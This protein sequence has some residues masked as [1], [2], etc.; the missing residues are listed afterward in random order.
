MMEL[1]TPL[2]IFCTYFLVTTVFAETKLRW[3]SHN[4]ELRDELDDAK[5]LRAVQSSMRDWEASHTNHPRKKRAVKRVCYGELGCFEDSGPFSYLEMLPSPPEEVNTKF[6]FYSTRNRSEQPLVELPYLNM[7]GEFTKMANSTT[8]E[9]RSSSEP[10]QKTSPF[11]KPFF[12]LNDMHR[13]DNMSV[14]IIVHGFGSACP[15]VWVYELKTALMAVENCVVICVDWEKGAELPNY[16]KAAANTRLVGKQLAQLLL[17]LSEHKGLDL[18]RTHLIGFSLG[19][20]ASGFAGAELPGLKRITGLDPAGPLFE[21]QHP[22]TRLDNSDADFVDVIHSNGENLILGGLGSWQPMGDVDFYPNGGRVQIG[23][24]NL[25]VGAVSDFIWSQPLSDEGRSLC[26]HRRAYKFFI[27]SVAPRC[28]FPS[29]PCE[30]YEKFLRGECFPCD[31]LEKPEN[32]TSMCGNMGYYA[33]RGPGRGQLYLVTREEEPF[34]A[35]QFQIQIVNSFNDLPLRTIGRLEATL[36]GESGLNETFLISEK[37]DTEFFAGDIV[38][39]IVVPHPALGFPTNLSLQYK[40]Y[41]G[42]LS[43]GL[44]H[45]DIDKI[46]LTDSFGKSHSLCNPSLKLISGQPVRLSLLPGDCELPTQTDYDYSSDYGTEAS[47]G[48]STEGIDKLDVN[49]EDGVETIKSK[50][51]ILNLGDTFKIKS[52]KSLSDSHD[53]HPVLEGNSLD[54]RDA[55]ESSRSFQAEVSEVYEPI[56]KERKIPKGRNIQD[57]ENKKRKITHRPPAKDNSAEESSREKDVITV[58]LFP[59][60]LGELLER[61][62]R[63]ARETLLP[64]IS[65]HTP[66]FFGFGGPEKK[67]ERKP[68][69]IPLFEDPKNTTNSSI[70]KIS[71]SSSKTSTSVQKISSSSPKPI[72]MK[73]IP[74]SAKPTSTASPKIKRRVSKRRTDDLATAE[75]SLEYKN[76]FDLFRFLNNPF[77]SEEKRSYA[78]EISYYLNDVSESGS[79]VPADLPEEEIKIDLPTYRPPKVATTT[80]KSKTLN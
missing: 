77:K 39:K 47:G 80:V 10:P 53:W 27:D 18:G 56:L 26:N 3:P 24:S 6:F 59:F 37:D 74:S 30:S 69:Y 38:S 48:T 23:C 64:L 54:N 34:C 72:P 76:I 43:K 65:E 36:E 21:S 63:Y 35:H 49:E 15:H 61:A 8:A 46:V 29:F 40:S 33:D 16:V 44:P 4:D 22:K 57:F 70:Q 58:Q 41:S 45:W 5:I 68:R 1:H 7:T 25:F 13:F 55:I 62:E 17:Q 78:P 71:S 75:S 52:N 73:V 42:W 51:D 66:R 28:R 19:A 79:L 31:Q 11:V 32:D 9:A 2:V 60:R 12:N 50:K 14:R 67:D 20:H